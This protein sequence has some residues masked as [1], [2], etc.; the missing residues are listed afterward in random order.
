[1]HFP[2][3]EFRIVVMDGYVC[4]YIAFVG[5]HGR[6]RK[7]TTSSGEDHMRSDHAAGAA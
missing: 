1:M 2:T 4:F 3:P 5:I 7:E 6:E